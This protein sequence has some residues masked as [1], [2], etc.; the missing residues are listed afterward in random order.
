MSLLQEDLKNPKEVFL[1]LSPKHVLLFEINKFEEVHR[2]SSHCQQRSEVQQQKQYINILNQRQSEPVISGMN[3]VVGKI[4][5]KLFSFVP[6]SFFLEPIYRMGSI[7][8]WTKFLIFRDLMK[9][10]P[11]CYK[12]CHL[13][14]FLTRKQKFRENER[15]ESLLTREFSGLTITCI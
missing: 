9:P 14:Y 6:V 7:F 3:L 2:L 8:N 12:L 15:F 13:F 10:C 1:F 5:Y 11:F 4:F